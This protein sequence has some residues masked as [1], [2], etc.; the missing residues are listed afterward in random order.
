[1]VEA[2]GQK[3]PLLFKAS[4]A[5]TPLYNHPV[6]IDGEPYVD[7]GIANP[8]PVRSAIEHGCTHILVL[9]TRANGFVGR[10]NLAERL[11]LAPLCRGWTPG[12]REAYFG[13]HMQLYNKTRAL[14]L[15]RNA[16]PGV[17]IAV[18]SPVV[19]SPLLDCATISRKKLLA[20]MEDA[21]RQTHE[22]LRPG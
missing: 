17:E 2:R 13:L 7:G 10:L 15:G 8:I 6:V 21:R 4:G 3:T 5:L 19:G 18:I 11:F 12:F 22:A 20:A 1:M 16:A 9:L 14:A